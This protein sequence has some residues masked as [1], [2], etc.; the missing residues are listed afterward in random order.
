MRRGGEGSGRAGA[1]RGAEAQGLAGWPRFAHMGGATKRRAARG[2]KKTQKDIGLVFPKKKTQNLGFRVFFPY[3]GGWWWQPKRHRRMCSYTAFNTHYR[4]GTS[5]R[6]GATRKASSTAQPMQGRGLTATSMRTTALL[7]TAWVARCIR[8]GRA[9]SLERG[10]RLL[11]RPCC[12]LRA[13]KKNTTAWAARLIR[14]G[15]A[16]A[17]PNRGGGGG[18][19]RALAVYK[20][21]PPKNKTK[22]RVKTRKHPQ[23]GRGTS[24]LA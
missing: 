7:S 8:S 10:R 11:A 9:A 19:A 3:L 22:H 20:P 18:C 16:T 13:P 1:G 15:R 5:R 21:P 4:G 6:R 17:R 24:S 12:V 2:R 23:R 14:A